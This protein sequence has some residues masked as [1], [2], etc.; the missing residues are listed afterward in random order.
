MPFQL[1]PISRYRITPVTHGSLFTQSIDL[2]VSGAQFYSLFVSHGI[3][4]SLPHLNLSFHLT[5]QI[6]GP[7][8]RLVGKLRSNRSSMRFDSTYEKKKGKTL[9]K[10]FPKIQRV[11]R[12]RLYSNGPIR[13]LE[14]INR[15][16]CTD[17]LCPSLWTH[18]SIYI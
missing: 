3:R 6:S 8:Y 7:S 15:V 2:L 17:S 16:L 1:S 9:E 13:F 10:F 5:I 11:L 18:I 12:F 14:H 4:S